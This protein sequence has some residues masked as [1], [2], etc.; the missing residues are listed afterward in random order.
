MR[1]INSQSNFLGAF[2][3]R[4]KLSPGHE[5]EQ[6][7]IRLALGISVF[8]YFAV[9]HSHESVVISKIGT[10]AIFYNLAGISILSWIYLNPTKTPLRYIIS[11]LV[12]VAVLSYAMSVSGKY[13]AALYPFYLWLTFGYGFR[14]GKP[15]L[16]FSALV[17]NVG[18]LFVYMTSPY[19]NQ[20]PILFGGLISGMIFLPLYVATLIHHLEQAVERARVANSAKSQFI[21]NMSHEL[22]TPLNGII[23]SN[24]LLKSSALTIEQKEYAETIGYSV[25]TLLGIIENVLD[26]SRIEAGH[27]EVEEKDFD[28]HHLLHQTTRMLKY[29]AAAKK[30]PLRLR[31]DPNVP[32]A[33]IGDDNHLRQILVNLTG[34]AIKYTDKGHIDLHISLVDRQ[35]TDC[36]IRFEIIDTG[37][38]IKKEDQA[39]IF[40]RFTQVDSSDTRSKGGTGLGTAI[41]KNLVET[42]GGTIG[43]QSGAVGV[44]SKPKKGSTFWFELPFTIREKDKNASDELNDACLLFLHD[45]DDDFKDMM[46]LLNTWGV[47]VIEA[48]SAKNALN[49]IIAAD[50]N[51][52]HIHTILIAKPLI[53]FNPNQFV[54][55]LKNTSILDVANLILLTDELDN[56]TKQSLFSTGFDYILPH[57]VNKSML[58]NAI[59]SSSLLICDHE[60]VET[61]SSHKQ[62]QGQ[63]RYQ[64]LLAEDNEVNQRIITRMLEQ[65]GHTVHVATNGEEALTALEDTHFDLCIFDM[66]M[67]VMGGLQAI[68]IFRYTYPDTE[69]PFII[70]TA[71]ATTEAVKQCKEANVDMYLTKPVRANQLLNAV[72]SIAPANPSIE[73]PQPRNPLTEKN[74]SLSPPDNSVLDVS[75]LD[76]VWD[77]QAEILNLLHIFIRQ[78]IEIQNKFEQIVTGDFEEF[79]SLAHTLKGIAGNMGTIALFD[80]TDRATKLSRNDY[81]KYARSHVDEIFQEIPPAIFALWQYAQQKSK[82]GSSI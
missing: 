56:K 51:E 8:M 49:I 18:L 66:Q 67:P 38:G 72:E 1:D 19:W 6:A 44:E 24:D 27:M 50:K 30:L 76:F 37:P 64:I 46:A 54:Q 2:F 69:M 21:A 4:I 35:D 20:Q 77:E 40:E 29:H 58:Y 31:V 41:A 22:R 75:Q 61:F 3:E 10:I 15:Y 73:I 5:Y 48:T 81:E 42:L 33:L 63:H 12:D 62:T 70:L 53:E 71:N 60:N 52:S 59:H 74:T 57:H 11:T 32:Y 7:F 43:V 25:N 36:T 9:F 82:A 47:T 80:A 78:S 65:G 14:F 26:I 23:G 45:D 68:K 39:A 17:S 55:Q 13:G 28:L 16:A 34:N 79:T